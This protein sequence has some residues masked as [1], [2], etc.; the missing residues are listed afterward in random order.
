MAPR[1]VVVDGSN[2]ATEGRSMPSLAQLDQAVREFLMENPDDVVTVVVDA[3]FGHRID[4]SESKIFE[5]AEAAA[6]LVSPP[7]GA[8]GR[9]DDF[10]LRIADKTGATVLSNDSFQ[11]FHGDYDWLFERGRLIGGKPVPGVGWIFTPRTPVRGPRSREAVKEA[12]RKTSAPP[13]I[14][15]EVESAMPGLDLAAER[16]RGKGKGKKNVERAIAVALEEAVSPVDKGRR[17]RK[18]GSPPAEPVNDPLAFIT[19]IAAHPLGAEVT[20]TVDSFASHGAFVECE[21]ARCYVPLS[22]MGDPP[23]KS[24]REVFTKGEVAKFVLQALDPQRRGVELAVPGFA[25]IA[26][27]PTDETVAAEIEGRTDDL[28]PAPPPAA[29]ATPAPSPAPISESAPA[30]AAAAPAPARSRSRS[31]SRGVVPAEP[32]EV[33]SGDAAGDEGAVA[34]KRSRKKAAPPVDG[35]GPVPKAVAKRSRVPKAAADPGAAASE[36][37]A[38]GPPVADGPVAKRAPSKRVP[39]KRAPPGSE[40]EAARAEP[41]VPSTAAGQVRARKRSTTPAATTATTAAA[42]TTTGGQPRADEPAPDPLPP[43]TKARA[44]GGRASVKRAQPSSAGAEPVDQAVPP[45]TGRR[46]APAAKK[47]QAVGAEGV[48]AVEPAVTGRRR[49]PAKGAASDAGPSPEVAALPASRRA[50]R[51]GA[52]ND[53]SPTPLEPLPTKAPTRARKAAAKS[54]PPAAPEPAAP[55]EGVVVVKRGRAKKAPG[56]APPAAAAQK[57]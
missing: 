35:A 40:P 29:P 36:G 49:A 27:A 47:E 20:A 5:E 28:V 8:I 13:R 6:E 17:R 19:F 2:I 45:V 41:A 34:P 9:G 26:G 51:R 55:E 33:A 30:A 7:A 24:A 4:G 48:A 56:A 1:H 57:G 22:G 11:E 12:R 37:G 42:T 39:S 53:R 25:K 38:A 50:G 46:R 14:G 15:D 43:P 10:L 16:A 44:R 18:G 3:S 32:A 21:G 31:R 52:V 23:P 54:P